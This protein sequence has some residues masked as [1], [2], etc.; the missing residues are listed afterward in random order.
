MAIRNAFNERLR[1]VL[2]GVLAIALAAAPLA[3]CGKGSASGRRYRARRSSKSSRCLTLLADPDAAAGQNAPEDQGAPSPRRRRRER[4][5]LPQSW[6]EDVQV[7]D[8]TSDGQGQDRL[9]R[10]GRQWPGHPL[11]PRLR[12][13]PAKATSWGPSPVLTALPSRSSLIIDQIQEGDGVSAETAQNLSALQDGVNDILDQL[14]GVD[15][16]E[17]AGN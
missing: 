15:G 1:S 3:A 10:H 17:A 6:G 14:Y 11:Q 2:A 9:H 13:T 16:F 12:V 8:N 7:K 5:V 4:L